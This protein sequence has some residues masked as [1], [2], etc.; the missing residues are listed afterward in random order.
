MPFAKAV[1]VW[2]YMSYAGGITRYAFDIAGEYFVNCLTENNK[3]AKI[4]GKD[5]ESCESFE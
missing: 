3:E 5:N 4:Y 2:A 1:V